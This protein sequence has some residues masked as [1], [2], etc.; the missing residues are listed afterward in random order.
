MPYNKYSKEHEEA[1]LLAASI[2][3][4]YFPTTEKEQRELVNM[5]YDNINIKGGKTRL[6]KAEQKYIF[7]TAQRIYNKIKDFLEKESNNKLK[8]LTIEEKI[9]L[10]ELK[11]CSSKG[12]NLD[13]K[14]CIM[15][16]DGNNIREIIRKAADIL[17]PP[18]YNFDPSKF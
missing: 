18:D 16:E 8:T 7:S 11:R 17:Y 3:Y 4:P 15:L 13:E 2:K 14:I 9:I 1:R 6:D 5:F 10:E 12:K